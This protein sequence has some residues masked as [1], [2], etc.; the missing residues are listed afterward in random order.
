MDREYRAKRI[1]GKGWIEGFY[2]EIRAKAYILQDDDFNSCSDNWGE[3]DFD[4]GNICIGSLA[5]EVVP[6]TVGQYIGIKDDREDNIFE[7]DIVM[8][9]WENKDS[10]KMVVSF[11][12]GA[13][14]FNEYAFCGLGK[15][16]IEKIGNIHD[17]PELLE[18]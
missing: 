9:Y 5:Y 3:A 4:Y 6:E 17:N 2:I 12:D 1:D 15:V 16:N 11:G 10:E 14:M 18:G 7:G 13:F 8:I